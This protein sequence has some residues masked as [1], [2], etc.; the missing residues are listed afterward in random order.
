M[1]RVGVGF[2]LPIFGG[3]L[4]YQV[5]GWFIRKCIFESTNGEAMLLVCNSIVLGGFWWLLAKL[6]A[7]S[8]DQA[9]TGR[10]L[11]WSSVIIG[12]LIGT[13]LKYKVA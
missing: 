3:V 8:D 7:A 13:V 11:W 4:G 2:P 9:H 6:D 12:G 10:T 5:T 1:H